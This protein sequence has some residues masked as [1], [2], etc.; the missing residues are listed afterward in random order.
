M[1]SCSGCGMVLGFKKYKFKKLWRIGGSYCK[2]CMM[3]IGKNWEDHGRVTLPMRA[4]DLCQTEFY[5]LKTAWQGKKQK[6][7]CDVC[8]KVAL[9]GVLP[10]K[11]RKEMTNKFPIPMLIIG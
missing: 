5:F 6:H 3:E 8:H 7:F 2:P 9:S 1:A 10:D 4:C 11:S